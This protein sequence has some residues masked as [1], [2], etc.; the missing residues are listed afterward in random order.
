MLGGERTK[1]TLQI[2]LLR[3]ISP[4]ELPVSQCIPLWSSLLSPQQERVLQEQL[5]AKSQVPTARLT[6]TRHSVR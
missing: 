6:G 1:C 2:L 3:L 4:N 5:S